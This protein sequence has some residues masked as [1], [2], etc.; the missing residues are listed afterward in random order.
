MCD[1][2]HNDT[3]SSSVEERRRIR[4]RIDQCISSLITIADE[5]E[6]INLHLSDQ[7][8][9]SFTNILKRKLDEDITTPDPKSRSLKHPKPTVNRYFPINIATINT[10][11]FN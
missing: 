7:P 10:R 4:N 1:N 6:H 8:P 9:N 2:Q 3:F 5:N 11:G